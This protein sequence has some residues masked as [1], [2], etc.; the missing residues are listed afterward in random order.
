MTK[1]R[2]KREKEMKSNREET[3]AKK[4]SEREKRRRRRR[5]STKCVKTSIHRC[6]MGMD[7]PYIGFEANKKNV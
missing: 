5:R 3:V 2:G 7:Q 6:N 4:R 1:E